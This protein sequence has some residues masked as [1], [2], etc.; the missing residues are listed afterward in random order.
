M[1]KGSHGWG[2]DLSVLLQAYCP[3]LV[4]QQLCI[5]HTHRD[6][7]MHTC[8]KSS[9]KGAAFASTHDRA[10]N[11]TFVQTA[12]A[13]LFL[14]PC[15]TPKS[16]ADD[17]QQTKTTILGEDRGGWRWKRGSNVRG[18]G[19]GM[20]RGSGPEGGCEAMRVASGG[21]SG[22]GRRRKGNRPGEAGEREGRAQAEASLEPK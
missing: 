10:P 2:C 21:G 18:R 8:A 9:G 3:A 14:E 13:D 7:N 12:I 19:W 17:E 22:D 16:M 20:E 11:R 15:T 4:R 1:W 6:T 5:L